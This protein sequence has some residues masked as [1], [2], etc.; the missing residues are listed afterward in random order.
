MMR[1]QRELL[2]RQLIFALDRSD[3]FAFKL[4]TGGSNIV[5]NIRTMRAS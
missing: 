4:G 1:A 5:H 3:K 2:L